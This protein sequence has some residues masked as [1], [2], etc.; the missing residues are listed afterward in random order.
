MTDSLM[1]E[2]HRRPKGERRRCSICNAPSDCT[3]EHR[4][5]ADSE[6]INHRWQSRLKNGGVKGFVLQLRVDVRAEHGAPV[7]LEAPATTT[8]RQFFEYV[9]GPEHPRSIWPH[10]K[11]GLRCHVTRL[12]KFLGANRCSPILPL[13]H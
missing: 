11:I 10:Y 5:T 2:W 4:A 13:R 6:R 3:G 8:L 7:I 9:F 1:H 12:G